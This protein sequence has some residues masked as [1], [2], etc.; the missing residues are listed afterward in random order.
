MV[1]HLFSQLCHYSHSQHGILSLLPLSSMFSLSVL[2][3]WPLCAVSGRLGGIASNILS[4]AQTAGF[5]LNNKDFEARQVW[6]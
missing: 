2:V 5:M 4:E 1:W 6:V 3:T